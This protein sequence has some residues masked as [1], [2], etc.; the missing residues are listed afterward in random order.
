MQE[1]IQCHFHRTKDSP[2]ALITQE[3]KTVLG[4]LCQESGTET[5]I[6]IFSFLTAHHSWSLAT[7]PF[8]QNDTQVQ[9][10]KFALLE[11]KVVIKNHSCPS[12]YCMRLS[13]GARPLRFAGFHSILSSFKSRHALSKH[14][15]S[16]FQ[17]SYI[18]ELR[19]YHVLL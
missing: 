7:D 15:A 5:N 12:S 19:Q 13:P 18:I 9:K 6:C 14:M 1:P 2:S 17:T 16:P 10:Y 11:S 3:I 4:I 8:H